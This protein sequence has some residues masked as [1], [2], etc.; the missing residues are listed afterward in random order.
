MYTLSLALLFIFVRTEQDLLPY[1]IISSIS[2][3]GAG[4]ANLIGRGKYCK[5]RPTFKL[6]LKEHLV[7]ILTI[8]MNTITTTIYVN[9]DML[10]LGL[11][12]SDEYTGLYTVSV[13]I[14]TIIKRVLAA[15][16]TVSIPRL[17]SYW[18]AENMEKLEDT[19]RKIFNVLLLIVMPAM[20][21]LFAMSKQVV[22][23]IAG[24]DYADSRSSLALLSL[25]LL[26]SLFSWFYTSCILIPSKNEKKVLKGTISAAVVNIVFNLIL[27]PFFQERAAA[28]TTC[29]AEAVA[30]GFGYFYSRKILRIKVQKRELLTVV[31]GC[32][33]I[34]AI[35]LA[36]NLFIGDKTAIALI[37]AIPASVICYA[38]VL[39][40]GKNRYAIDILHTITRK[41]KKSPDIGNKND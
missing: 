39:L 16:I 28:V 27:I 2:V 21:G 5:I 25:A 32:I 18:G 9:S 12:T 40:V 35:C 36:T 15:V 11:M 8:F 30:L 19:T 24:R 17:S 33:G 23:L 6:N 14:Y 20:I 4:L 1:A 37:V 38:A 7:P 29:M 22:L 31:L 34:F 3:S 13:R 10:I 41:I 26:F